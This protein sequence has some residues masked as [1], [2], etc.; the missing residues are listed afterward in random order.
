MLVKRR[1][2]SAVVAV[3]LGLA[4]AACGARTGYADVADIPESLGTDRTSIVVGDPAADT[5]VRLYEDPRCPACK[6]F[7]TKGAGPELHRMTMKGTV[8]VHYTFASFLDGKLGGNGSKK[9][10]NA[11]RAALEEGKF[12]E[13]HQVLYTH[14]PEE[15]VDGFTDALLLQMASQVEGLRGERF[16]T[17]VRTMKYQVFVDASEKVFQHSTAVGTPAMEVNDVPLPEHQDGMILF[18]KGYFTRYIGEVVASQPS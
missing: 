6:E 7:E 1:F 5:T 8:Q 17:A 12:V 18:D 3:G 9:A 13:Y 10:V 15:T 11:L 4:V 2:L 14:Q 16:D